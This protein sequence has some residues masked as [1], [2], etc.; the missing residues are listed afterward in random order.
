[1]GRFSMGRS[2]LS[3]DEIETRLGAL[4]GWSLRGDKLFRELKFGSFVEAFGFMASAAL[5][6]ESLNHHPEWK[7]VYSTVTVE[8]TTHDAGGLTELDFELASRMSEL[9]TRF[10]A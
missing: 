6:A 8:L 2:K 7:N 9:V 3:N 4:S 10:G 5:V 1:M